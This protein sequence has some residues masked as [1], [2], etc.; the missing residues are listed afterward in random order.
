MSKENFTRYSMRE[1]MLKKV[2]IRVDYDGV[3]DISKWVETFKRTDALKCKF[4]NY[5]QVQLNKAKFD[6]SNND[7]IAKQRSIPIK[8][9]ESEPIHRFYDSLF[10]NR[11]DR[12]V[13]DIARLFMTFEIDCYQYKTIDDYFDY[14]LSYLD[15]FLNFDTYIKIKRIGIRK[16]GGESFTIL[17]DINKVFE[18]DYFECPKID[19]ENRLL[20]ERSFHDKFIK[21]LNPGKESSRL[22]K[23]NYATHCRCTNG[24]KTYQAILDIDGYVDDFIIKRNQLSFPSD[25]SSTFKDINNYLFELYKKSVTEQYLSEHGNKE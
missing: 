3:T 20:M 2:L 11:Q 18:S 7:E 4:S 15:I 17:E 13:M 12:I 19:D 24:G 21:E 23:V 25:L 14:L 5:S 10:T 9:L 1:N 6:L 16:T 22:V 8:Y